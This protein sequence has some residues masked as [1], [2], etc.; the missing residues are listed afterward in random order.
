[1]ISSYGVAKVLIRIK[2]DCAHTYILVVGSCY[3]CP[4][5]DYCR[6]S[7]RFILM[8]SPI[9]CRAKVELAERYIAPVWAN[10]I[11]GGSV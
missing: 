10:K 9:R 5:R 6:I 7:K 4:V 2:G 11:H 1:M 8:E 3:V